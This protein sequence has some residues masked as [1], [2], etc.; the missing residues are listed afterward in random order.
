MLHNEYNSKYLVGKKNNGCESQRACSQD[1][2]I[3]DKQPVV[4]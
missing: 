1:E 4:K 2:L 3:G